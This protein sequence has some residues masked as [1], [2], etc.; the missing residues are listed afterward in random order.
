MGRPRIH[1]SHALSL[2]SLPVWLVPTPAVIT[3]SC[4]RL[5]FPSGSELFPGISA[6]LGPTT[7]GLCFIDMVLG[8]WMKE[9]LNE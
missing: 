8:G 1:V 5:P 9:D 3:V 6:S 4:Q 2:Y 7:H